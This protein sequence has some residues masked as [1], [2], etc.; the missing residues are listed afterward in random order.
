MELPGVKRARARQ[1]YAAGF[2]TVAEVAAAE[3]GQLVSALAPFLSR[4]A[5]TGIVHSA[6]MTLVDRVESLNKEAAE[7]AQLFT[8]SANTVTTPV[9]ND[10]LEEEDA[11][12]FA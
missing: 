5:A 4:R 7:I 11:D 12:L 2:K 9:P 1:L 8:S 3:P 10:E 6:R